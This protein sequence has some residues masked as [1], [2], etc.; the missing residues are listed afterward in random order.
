MTGTLVTGRLVTGILMT[1]IQVT[2][3]LVTRVLLTDI[4][5]T[6]SNDTLYWWKHVLILASIWFKHMRS[7]SFVVFETPVSQTSV[8]F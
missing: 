7:N 6:G 4:L 8:L 1:G 3:I 2:G 5:V